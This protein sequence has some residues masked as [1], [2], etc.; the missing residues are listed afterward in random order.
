MSQREFAAIMLVL[1]SEKNEGGPV[2]RSNNEGGPVRR[3]NNEGGPVLRYLSEGK[4][5]VITII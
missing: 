4:L 3:S 1:R 5:T 2:R